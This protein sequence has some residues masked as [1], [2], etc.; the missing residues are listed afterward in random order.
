MYSIISDKM[1]CATCGKNTETI[2]ER[3][4]EGK[5]RCVIR[6]NC[7]VCN[8]GKGKKMFNRYGEITVLI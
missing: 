4:E 3:K 7:K 2:N 1:Y 5:G 8:A 6:G